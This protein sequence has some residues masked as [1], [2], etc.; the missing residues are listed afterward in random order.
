MK[1]CTAA[2][3][4]VF[5][6]HIFPAHFAVF[7]FSFFFCHFLLFSLLLHENEG[8]HYLCYRALEPRHLFLQSS[9]HSVKELVNCRRSLNDLSEQVVKSKDKQ[10]DK[11]R[12]GWLLFF[13]N[14]FMTNVIEKAVS[15][16]IIILQDR[17]VK[18]NQL[19]NIKVSSTIRLE[20]LEEKKVADMVSKGLANFIAKR[21]RL[22]NSHDVNPLETIWIIVDETINI[23]ISSPQNTGRAKTVTMLRLEKCFFRH[24]LGARIFYM[25]PLRKHQKT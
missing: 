10:E 14:V 13:K 25:S 22:A 6:H 2:H 15:V 21:D 9:G 5:S 24:T 4:Q 11:P 23:Q 8:L 19:K 7:P 12:S 17:K 1:F 16:C 20:S 18:E 3:T